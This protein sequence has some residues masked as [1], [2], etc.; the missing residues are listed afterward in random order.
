MGKRP[1]RSARCHPARAPASRLPGAPSP[2]DLHDSRGPSLALPARSPRRE[3][4]ARSSTLS[5]EPRRTRTQESSREPGADT[6]GGVSAATAPYLVQAL[7]A[8]PGGGGDRWPCRLARGWA[9]PPGRSGRR[10]GKKRGGRALCRPPALPRLQREPS[11]SP[12]P[13]RGMIGG[14]GEGACATRGLTTPFPGT[15]HLPALGM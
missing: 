11:P 5:L 14:G 12:S 13:P 10:R 1:P 6:G 3:E 15:A 8:G 4:S 7:P 9:S 2:A